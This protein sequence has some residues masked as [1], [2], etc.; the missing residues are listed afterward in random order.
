MGKK[1]KTKIEL[2]TILEGHQNMHKSHMRAIIDLD[3]RL[4]VVENRGADVGSK[5][6]MPN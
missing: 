1:T 6:I 5:I 4:R 3:R 2:G